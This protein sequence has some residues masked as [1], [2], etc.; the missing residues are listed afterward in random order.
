MNVGIAQ[1][2]A[3]SFLGMHNWIFGYSANST[4][5][6]KAITIDEALN[7]EYLYNIIKNER[8]CWQ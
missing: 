2:R 3:V 6:M 4:W 5:S 7:R 8:F 1:N